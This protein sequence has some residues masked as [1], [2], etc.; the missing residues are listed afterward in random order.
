MRTPIATLRAEAELALDD[1]DPEER[2]AAASVTSVP[3]SLAAAATPAL[4]G[5]LFA[6]GYLAWPL[7]LAGA[8]KS[9]Y[10]VLLLFTFRS[11]VLDDD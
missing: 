3:R 8:A 2:T 9:T 4:A 10:D 11:V 1:P 5:W 7:V 6:N